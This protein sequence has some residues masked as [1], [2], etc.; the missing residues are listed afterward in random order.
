LCS[1]E[2]VSRRIRSTGYRI[3]ATALS[4]AAQA[5]PPFPQNLHQVTRARSRPPRRNPKEPDRQRLSDQQAELAKREE[6][7]RRVVGTVCNSDFHQTRASFCRSQKP[8][9]AIGG[10][11]QAGAY[12]VA[13]QFGIIGNDLIVREPSR[14]PAEHV[15]NRYSQSSDAGTAPAL[16]VLYGYDVLVIHP[17][18]PGAQGLA[19]KIAWN[20]ALH[21]PPIRKFI[22]P[23]RLSDPRGLP[24]LLTPAASP[25]RDRSGGRASAAGRVRARRRAAHSRP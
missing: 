6:I 17:R 3:L 2:A 5:R 4:A 15:S 1:H 11:C 10:I 24:E 9:L 13:S 22:S 19:Y 21:H 18:H 7:R 25:A 12:V 23:R 16:T 14:Q 8:T 20:I